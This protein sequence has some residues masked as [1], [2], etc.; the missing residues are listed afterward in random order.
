MDKVFSIKI[1]G[2]CL[3]GVGETKKI[4]RETGRFAA[5]PLIVFYRDRIPLYFGQSS[6]KIKANNFRWKAR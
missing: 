6:G 4:C 3:L 2:G 1:C 5:H